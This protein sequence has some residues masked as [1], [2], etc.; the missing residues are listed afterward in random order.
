[1]APVRLQQIDKLKAVCNCEF[2]ERC[3]GTAATKHVN[4]ST[5]VYSSRP[6]SITKLHF[7]HLGIGNNQITVLSHAK[8]RQLNHAQ[9]VHAL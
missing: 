5:L 1:M 7:A 9:H 4:W 3:D 8:H 6:H 2:R